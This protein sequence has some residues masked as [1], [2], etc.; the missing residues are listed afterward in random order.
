[1]DESSNGDRGDLC[2]I[3]AEDAQNVTQLCAL[4]LLVITLSLILVKAFSWWFLPTG[5]PYRKIDTS[6]FKFKSPEM[7]IEKDVLWS[8]K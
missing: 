7:E 6:S 8:P 3:A 1:M 2:S 5:T 4:L